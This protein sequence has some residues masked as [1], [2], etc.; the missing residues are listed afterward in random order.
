MLK[1]GFEYFAEQCDAYFGH[2]NDTRALA[3]DLAAGFEETKYQ[4][5]VA[6][7]HKSISSWKKR[8]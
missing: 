1:Y 5:I 3:V 7:Y 2:V 6:H 8:N 4:Y